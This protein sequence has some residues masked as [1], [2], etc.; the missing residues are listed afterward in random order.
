M[1]TILIISYSILFTEIG[2]NVLVM[3][4]L[5]K[6]KRISIESNNGV[7]YRFLVKSQDDLL[8][9]ARTMELN[10]AINSFLKKDPD[11]K[12]SELCKYFFNP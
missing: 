12:N 7:E 3:K 4:S 6:P 5:Q 2:N 8:K 11:A 10:Y 1:R 9:D